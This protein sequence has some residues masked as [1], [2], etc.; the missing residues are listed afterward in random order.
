MG[1][2][3]KTSQATGTQGMLRA[4]LFLAF[5]HAVN[6]TRLRRGLELRSQ[7]LLAGDQFHPSSDADNVANTASQS[8]PKNENMLKLG[9]TADNIHNDNTLS[10]TNSLGA[11]PWP[12]IDSDDPG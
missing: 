11:K 2:K 3:K 12:T 8:S 10:N 1:A 9:N 7:H 5:L 6:A 4:F